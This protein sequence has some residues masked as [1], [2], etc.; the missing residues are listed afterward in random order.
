MLR[1]LK[2]LDL[3]SFQVNISWPLQTIEGYWLLYL[4][5]IPVIKVWKPAEMMKQLTNDNLH[6]S[7]LLLEKK[8]KN[9]V[10]LIPNL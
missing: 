3:I 8:Q 4:T 9:F 5:D 10:K 6:F 7:T 1:K 2:Y